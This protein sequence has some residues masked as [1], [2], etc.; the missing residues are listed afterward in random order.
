MQTPS[1]IRAGLLALVGLCG[2][3][4][5]LAAGTMTYCSDAAPEGFDIAQYETSASFDVAIAIYDSL[6]R[7]DATTGRIVP[8]LAEKWEASADGLTYTL[9]L[10]QGVKFHS[11]PWFTPSREFNADDVLFSIGRMKDKTH[12]AHSGARNGFVYWEG[13]S[14]SALVKS[15]EKVDAM[16]VRFVLAKPEVPFLSNLA[17]AT[18]GSMF[19]AEYAGQLLKAGK[20]EQ[21]NNQPVGTGPFVFKSYQ[22]D[23]VIR[24]GANGAYWGGVP[25]VDALVFSITVDP[26]VR[27]QRLKAGECLLADIKNESAPAFDG[28]ASVAVMRYSPLRTAFIAPNAEHEF[29]R[30]KRLR[31]ALWLALDKKTLIQAVYGGQAAPAAAFLPSAMWGL[32]KSLKDRYDPDKARQLVKA[33]GYDGRELTFFIG[34]D[35]SVKRAGELLQADWAAVGVKVKVQPLELGE[36]FKRAGKGEH[37]LMLMRWES[38]NGDP[39]NFFTPN[40]ACAA[41]AGGGNKARWCNPAFDALIEEAR[42]N[43]DIGKRTALY[44]RAQRLLYDEVG[45]IPLVYPMVATALNKR[46]Q[47]YRT[48]PLGLHDF[49]GVSLR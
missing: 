8:A 9:H 17:I 2:S 13:M 42:T 23:A 15:V 30:D 29:T 47:G 33:S 40:L 6:V 5:A 49:S 26:D 39:D 14:M 36:L 16:T 34:N 27:V 18:L 20:L 10:R 4:L 32:D 37:D 44:L 31:E 7:L 48:S 24:F 21:M 11:T 3:A 1:S 45:V 28:H 19:S 43:A 35:S 25:K 46:V 12:P 22:K 38:D 41:V